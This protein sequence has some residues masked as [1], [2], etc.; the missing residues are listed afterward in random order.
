M[1]KQ[2]SLGAE[3]RA[4]FLALPADAVAEVFNFMDQVRW[5]G[6]EGDSCKAILNGRVFVVMREIAGTTVVLAVDTAD[7]SV[8]LVDVRATYPQTQE[9]LQRCALALGEHVEHEF[10]PQAPPRWRR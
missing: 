3:I 10:Y 7:G 5:H 6:V 4:A 8:T 2:E 1:P 9:A